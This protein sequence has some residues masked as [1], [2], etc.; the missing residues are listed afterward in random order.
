M[1]V[2]VLRP[3]T[4]LGSQNVRNDNAPRKGRELTE[5]FYPGSI[6][7]SPFIYGIGGKGKFVMYKTIEKYIVSQ[8]RWIQIKTQLNHARYFPSCCQFEE[9]YIYIFG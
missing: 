1:S 8:D 5:G 9:K 2:I 4:Q 3:L 7:Y 6:C